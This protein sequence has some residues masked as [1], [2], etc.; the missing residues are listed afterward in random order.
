MKTRIELINHCFKQTEHITPYTFEHYVLMELLIR[1][2][3]KEYKEI[4]ENYK[5][6]ILN[7]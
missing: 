5:Q 2:S 1:I 7:E 3:D 4:C 6:D